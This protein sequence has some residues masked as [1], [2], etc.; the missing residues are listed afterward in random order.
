MRLEYA[1]VIV[2]SVAIVIA[3]LIVFF[4]NKEQRKEKREA[5]DNVNK[6]WARALDATDRL[7]EKEADALKYALACKD[8]LIAEKDARIQQLEEE[9]ALKNMVLACA[10]VDGSVDIEALKKMFQDSYYLEKVEK[11][12]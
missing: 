2:L 8:D 11:N 9:I 7:R 6:S 5:V 10:K 3:A 1:L 4:S 12:G